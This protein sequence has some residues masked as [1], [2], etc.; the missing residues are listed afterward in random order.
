MGSII[1]VDLEEKAKKLQGIRDARR[2]HDLDVSKKTDEAIDIAVAKYAEFNGYQ[3]IL[4]NRSSSIAYNGD[5]VT[6]DVTDDV[7]DSLLK[8]QINTKIDKDE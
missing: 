2:K 3:L 1:I 8:N 4:T 7:L 5:K 6:I